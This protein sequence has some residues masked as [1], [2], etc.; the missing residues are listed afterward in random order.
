MYSFCMT[1]I[2]GPIYLIAWIFIKLFPKILKKGG[3]H[4]LCDWSQCEDFI[5][6][7]ND[8]NAEWARTNITTLFDPL[9]KFKASTTFKDSTVESQPQHYKP[10]KMLLLLFFFILV[11]QSKVTSGMNFEPTIFL[12]TIGSTANSICYSYP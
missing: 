5:E 10:Y 2:F 12:N 7:I 4:G 6:I 1:Y 9:C 3:S 11:Y 8:A